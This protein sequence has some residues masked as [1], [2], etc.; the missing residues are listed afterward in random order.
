M[1]TLG[2]DLGTTKVAAVLY[3]PDASG[4]GRAV[5][6]EH[7]AALPTAP[8]HAEQDGEKM[9]AAVLRLLAE[10]PPRELGRVEAVGLTGQMHSVIL[11]SGGELSPAVTWQDKRA[12]A[13]GHLDEFR[14]LSGRPLA[15][16][17]G[18]VTLA[19]LARQGELERWRYA[20]SPADW[21][22]TR[23]TGNP[24]PVTDPTFAASW[25]IFDPASGGWDLKAAAALGIPPGLLPPVVASGSIVGTTRNVPG[26]PDGIP[27]AAPFGDNQA[28]VL[29]TAVELD[30]E[31][32]LTLGT[33][34]QF[35]FVISPES[36][37]GW[38]PPP[39]VELRPFL[40][41]KLLAVTAPLCGGRAWAWLGGAVNNFLTS[42]GLEPLPEKLLLDR[43]DALA[44]EVDG[45]SAPVVAPH[46]LGERHNPA[47]FGSIAGITLEN[48]TLPNLARG[49]AAGIVRN[50][51]DSFPPEFYR[52]RE[53]VVGS[54]NCVRFC[55]SIRREIERQFD[56]P[57]EI[58]S[59]REEAA[60]GA[61][62]LAA[63]SVRKAG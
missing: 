8:G 14:T 22:A 33:G 51:G 55:G 16:G 60:V 5:S 61:A 23:L 3:D 47:E 35:S 42:L 13:A 12:S 59:V 38:T 20:A 28:S 49:L 10:L 21:L 57:L 36:A 43:L 9:Y 39:A 40:D 19:E 15:D 34:A 24:A 56:L 17:F 1:L 30:R 48:F 25:G 53:R 37:A 6:T 4:A 52:N 11:W 44:L 2:I 32:F 29:G 62:R 7:H 50:L 45:E 54:G 41:G 31:L 27:V 18:A 63:R 58:R 26:I 46:F